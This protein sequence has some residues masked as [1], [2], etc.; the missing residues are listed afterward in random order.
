MVLCMLSLFDYYLVLFMF[1][2]LP[3]STLLIPVVMAIV[4]AIACLQDDEGPSAVRSA[5]RGGKWLLADNN[6]QSLIADPGRRQLVPIKSVLS[7][8]LRLDLS[9]EMG[10]CPR[11]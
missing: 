8:G 6:E 4:M 3:N 5:L 9:T 7:P 1:M 2:I 10:D 11:I